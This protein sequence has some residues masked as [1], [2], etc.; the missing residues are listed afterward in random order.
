MIYRLIFQSP[1]GKV[2]TG[3]NYP[4]CS[5]ANPGACDPAQFNSMEEAEA[6]AAARGE[7]P[8]VVSSPEEA[9]DIA[10][11]RAQPQ[12]SIFANKWVLGGLALIAWRFLKK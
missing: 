10:E 12:T 1:N 2:D 9:W 6:Y 4:G 7:E 11:G 3:A 5:L 8:Y